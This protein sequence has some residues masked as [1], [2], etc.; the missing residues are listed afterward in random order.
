DGLDRIDRGDRGRPD[1]RDD[2]CC[3]RQIERLGKQRE[4]IAARGLTNIEAEQ[5]GGL[6]DRGVRVLGADDDAAA[7]RLAR[8]GECGNRRG[9]GGVLDVPVPTDGQAEVLRR[10]VQRHELQLG[11]GG[12]LCSRQ[13]EG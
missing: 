10:P 11:G 4:V 3:I 12:R 9:R 6:V 7:V 13:T 2:R 5:S 1:G 8:G